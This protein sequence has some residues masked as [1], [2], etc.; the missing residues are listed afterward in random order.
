MAKSGNTA[1]K[2]AGEKAARKKSGQVARVK[3]QAQKYAEKINLN[4]RLDHL[5]AQLE[6]V[7]EE[8]EQK[9]EALWHQTA[10]ASLHW[11][12]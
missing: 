7:W 10:V 5:K 12:S 1:K 6:Q 4:E 3:G 8:G 2:A 9:S 11:M